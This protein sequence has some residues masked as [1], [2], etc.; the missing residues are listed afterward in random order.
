MPRNLACWYS[1]SRDQH[2]PVLRSLVCAAMAKTSNALCRGAWCMAAPI[3]KTSTALCR[4]AWC[5]AAAIAKTSTALPDLIPEGRGGVLVL[6]GFS[7][8][9]GGCGCGEAAVAMLPIN[10]PTLPI[11]TPTA[12]HCIGQH[13]KMCIA[14][15]PYSPYKVTFQRAEWTMEPY[16]YLWIVRWSLLGMW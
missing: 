4:G 8:Y 13:K 2:C 7:H 5:M 12:T 10:T 11:N 1:S 3:A 9:Y 15:S 14:Y 6:P 16:G